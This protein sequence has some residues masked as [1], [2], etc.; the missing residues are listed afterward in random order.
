[1]LRRNLFW[2]VLA[3]IT[4]AYLGFWLVMLLAT[5]T[6]TSPLEVFG[7]LTS[8]EIR[9][10]TLLS[11]I[12]CTISALASVILAVPIGY[13]MSR[14]R[15][16][17]HSLVDAALDIPIVLPPMVVGICL[18]IFFQTFA[19]KLI[20]QVIPFTYTVAGVVLAQFVIAAAFAIRTM[21]QVFDHLSPRPEDVALTL[22]ATRWQAL[23]HVTLPAAR[24]GMFAAGSVAWARSLGEFGPILV[25]AG[26]TRMKTEVLPTSVWLAW[27]VGELE[28]GVAVSLLMIVISMI[29]LVAVKWSGERT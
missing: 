10:A 12:T 19:G 25:F 15:F 6:Y 3:L 14:K 27:S 8:R 21:R 5:A 17:G 2:L 13:L 26:A 28:Q 29:I 18:L 4:A 11:V 24:R 9:Y 16:P 22:G 23:W 7:V 1:M 20:E